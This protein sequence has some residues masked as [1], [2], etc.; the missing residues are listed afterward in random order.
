MVE[1]LCAQIAD[2]VPIGY[3]FRNLYNINY[4]EII[5]CSIVHFGKNCMFIF[6]EV[7]IQKMNIALY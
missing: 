7:N 1:Q 4:L 5:S 2:Y 3:T 6:C